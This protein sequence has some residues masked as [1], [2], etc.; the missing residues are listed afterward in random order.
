MNVFVT[1]PY[2]HTNNNAVFD[3]TAMKYLKVIY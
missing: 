3:E 1:Q 2:L